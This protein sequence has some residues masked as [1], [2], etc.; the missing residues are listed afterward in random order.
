MNRPEIGDIVRYL[1]PRSDYNGTGY[2]G[3]SADGTWLPA[4]VTRVWGLPEDESPLVNLRVIRD[5]TPDDC[6]WVTSVPHW[7]SEK[8]D[9]KTDQTTGRAWLRRCE[10]LD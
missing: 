10:K 9:Q 4:V 8:P 3:C 6:E 7:H 1:P 2:N 5:G